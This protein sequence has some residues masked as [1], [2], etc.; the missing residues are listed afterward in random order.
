[1]VAVSAP[2]RFAGTTGHPV[3]ETKTGYAVGMDHGKVVTK[4]ELK[5]RPSHR[6]GVRCQ[7]PAFDIPVAHAPAST[8]GVLSGFAR[9]CRL[10]AA[11]GAQHAKTHLST[12]AHA[13]ADP[14]ALPPLPS[15]EAEQARCICQGGYP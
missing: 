12:S 9:L 15:A 5:P 7:D 8:H 4:L 14:C 1:M 10:L 6:K 2:T 11:P 13:P 3:G